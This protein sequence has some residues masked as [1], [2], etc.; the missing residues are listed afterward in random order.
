MT[1][2]LSDA[3]MMAGVLEFFSPLLYDI[4]MMLPQNIM[5]QMTELITKLESDQS[6]A[7]DIKQR[8]VEAVS[9][10]CMALQF[11]RSYAHNVVGRQ[12]CKFLQRKISMRLILYM[13]INY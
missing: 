6:I 13:K 9:S 12:H 2:A 8:I 10:F 7:D 5:D 11:V 3:D 1:Q 4:E